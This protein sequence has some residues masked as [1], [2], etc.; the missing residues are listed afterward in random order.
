MGN[1]KEAPYFSVKNVSSPEG[2]I[3]SARL[4]YESKIFILIINNV[5]IMQALNEKNYFCMFY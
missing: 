1:G 3:L 2:G 5:R 4:K